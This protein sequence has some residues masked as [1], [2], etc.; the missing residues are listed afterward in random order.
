MADHK[1]FFVQPRQKEEDTELI[2]K[3]KKKKKGES[4]KKIKTSANQ[5]PR[6]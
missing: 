4:G 5:P 2:A 3:E 1:T 6:H